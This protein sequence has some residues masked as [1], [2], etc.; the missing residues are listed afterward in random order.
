MPA[1]LP[2]ETVIVAIELLMTG[3][4][5]GRTNIGRLNFR[6]MSARMN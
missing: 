4:G 2:E 5:R 6:T 3:A 1:L